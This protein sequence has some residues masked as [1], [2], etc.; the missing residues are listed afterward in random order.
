[1]TTDV[2]GSCNLGDVLQVVQL[3]SSQMAPNDRAAL[4]SAVL[5]TVHDSERVEL[6][7]EQ[8]VAMDEADRSKMLSSVAGLMTKQERTELIRMLQGTTFGDE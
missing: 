1:V 8:F 6:V 2:L 3:Q 5:E 4:V 7:Q